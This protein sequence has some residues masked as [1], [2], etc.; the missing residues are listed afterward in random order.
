MIKEKEGLS[1]HEITA[2]VSIMSN[3]F[4]DNEVVW[5]Y[6]LEQDMHNNGYN[7]LA[8]SIAIKKL[9]A[10]QFIELGSEPDEEGRPITYFRI[11]KAGE[12]WIIANEDRLS[13]KITES[14]N[15]NENDDLPF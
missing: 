5:R 8:V 15:Y 14:E 10:R 4:S 12:D 13:L 1:H 6:T 7:S 9:K 2:L 11:T 3:Q